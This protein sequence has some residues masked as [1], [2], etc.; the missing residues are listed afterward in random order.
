MLAAL[1]IPYQARRWYI[2]S[3]EHLR[4]KCHVANSQL[5]ERKFEI[6]ARDPRYCAPPPRQ[7]HPAQHT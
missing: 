4:A 5:R 2:S 7:L 6:G 3:A 1:M